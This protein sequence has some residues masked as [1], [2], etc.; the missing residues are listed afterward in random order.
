MKA[1]VLGTVPFAEGPVWCDDGTL[2]V[3]STAVGALYRV[4]PAGGRVEVAADLGGGANGAAPAAGGGFLVC[5]NGGFDFAEFGVPDPPAYR[6]VAPGL[7][8]VGPDGTVRYLAKDGTQAPNDLVV[9]EDNSIYFTDPPRVQVKRENGELR[10]VLPKEKIGRVWKLDPHGN[11]SLYADKLVFP[12]G[13]GIDRDGHVVII[14]EHGLMRLGPGGE[15]EWV[16][17]NLGLGGGDGFC[18][19]I[20]GNFYVA[21]TRDACVRVV[22]PG[23]KIIDVLPTPPANPGQFATNCC[24]GGEGNRT[25]YCSEMPGRVSCWRDMPIPGR[26]LVQWTT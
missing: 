13:I 21:G 14:E 1:E 3:C 25:L 6:P 15:R 26:P 10:H 16:I 4:W 8:H 19:D 23:G 24:F 7:Q 18:L 11:L 17:E 2:V 22:D 12:N 9:A 5:Q 20:E